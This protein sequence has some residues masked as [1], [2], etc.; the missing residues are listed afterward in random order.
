ML[1]PTVAYIMFVP[2][3]SIYCTFFSASSTLLPL[4]L[5]NKTQHSPK[6][7]TST[8]PIVPPSTHALLPVARTCTLINSTNQSSSTSGPESFSLTSFPLAATSG[9]GST[10]KNLVLGPNKPSYPKCV[11][12]NGFDACCAPESAWHA[13][14][15]TGHGT[16]T[17][18]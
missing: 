16:G 1:K 11:R 4:P 14:N 5:P 7:A 13:Q 17:I 9:L 15:T 2:T 12:S 10:C 6:N 3:L 18:R 8:T